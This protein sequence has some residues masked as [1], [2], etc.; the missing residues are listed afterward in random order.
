MIMLPNIGVLVT[1]NNLKEIQFWK[2]ERNL[3]LETIPKDQFVTCLAAVESYGKLI[4]GTKDKCIIEVDLNEAFKSI[5]AKFAK[6]YEQTKDEADRFEY[7]D[8]YGTSLFL[9]D[10]VNFVETED[11]KL[12]DNKTIMNSLNEIND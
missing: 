1:C 5:S 9:Q 4:C 10:K 6:K 12:I 3:L 2:Y 7:D 11:D 8:T